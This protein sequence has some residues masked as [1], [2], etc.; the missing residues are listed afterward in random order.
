M[1]FLSQ[2]LIN[3]S[4]WIILIGITEH[5][6]PPLVYQISAQNKVKSKRKKMKE[7]KTKTL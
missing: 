1:E 5:R 7:W 6:L 2:T 3:G 4:Q